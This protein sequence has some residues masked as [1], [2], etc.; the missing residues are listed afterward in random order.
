[1]ASISGHG[2]KIRVISRTFDVHLLFPR[3]A[4]FRGDKMPKYWEFANSADERAAYQ[5]ILGAYRKLWALLDKRDMNGFLDACEERSREIDSAFYKRPG[6]TRARL[7]KDVES[8]MN[9]PE[10]RL[11]PVENS[12]GLF[13]TYTVGSTGR[14]IALTQGDRASPIIRYVMK[15]GTPFSLIFPIVFRKEGPTYIVTR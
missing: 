10:F 15:D 11:S 7:R 8:A 9:D 1:M 3:W 14:L 4:F 6:E 2:T 5:E 13:W 12:P